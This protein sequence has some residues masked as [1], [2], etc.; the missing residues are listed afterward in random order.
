MKEFKWMQTK[1]TKASVMHVSDMVEMYGKSNYGEPW[2]K[3]HKVCI[4]SLSPLTHSFIHPLMSW[5]GRAVNCD[6]KKNRQVNGDIKGWH[7]Q[8]LA[9]YVYGFS[10]PFQ[11][12][13]Y[14]EYCHLQFHLQFFSFW[15][16]AKRTN[17]CK[18]KRMSTMPA[19][20]EYFGRVFKHYISAFPFLVY[21]LITFKFFCQISD[22][23][24]DL[25]LVKL[26]DRMILCLESWT[27]K[28]VYAFNC[29]KY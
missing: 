19:S 4:H 12:S 14:H 11:S 13:L 29:N 1:Q 9:L 28:P 3:S 25:D 17:T 22:F 26:Q 10:Q 18:Q 20:Q 16:F 6:I 27:L 24:D 7:K 21:S 15:H 5:W 2:W 8:N 23:I